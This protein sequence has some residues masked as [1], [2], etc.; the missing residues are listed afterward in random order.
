MAVTEDRESAR[1]ADWHRLAAGS[2]PVELPRSMRATAGCTRSDGM[3]RA[4]VGLTT[5][6]AE[7]L[8]LAA[9]AFDVQPATVIASA[10]LVVL[11][12]YSSRRD[13]RTTLRTRDDDGSILVAPCAVSWTA[14]HTFGELVATVAGAMHTA[15]RSALPID[16]LLGSEPATAAVLSETC[17]RLG[18]AG[19]ASEVV[20]ACD[21]VV[22]VGAGDDDDVNVEIDGEAA[23]PVITVLGAADRFD[24]DAVH[25]VA[26]HL[27]TVIETG[28]SDPMRRVDELPL[29]PADEWEQ[30]VRSWN[31]TER[32]RPDTTL[33]ELID[34]QV[35][36]T[37]DALAVDS[38]DGSLTYEQLRATAE[39]WSS[40]LRADGVG[41]GQ[42]VAVCVPRGTDMVAAVLAV[43]RSGAAYLPI[44]PQLPAERVAFM[45]RDSDAAAVLCTADTRTLVD[46]H[47]QPVHVLSGDLRAATAPPAEVGSDD[48]AY[49]LYTSGS[50]GTPKGV[51]LTHRNAVNLVS[52]IRDTFSVEERRRIMAATS[53]SWDLSITELFGSLCWGTTAVIV[54][55]VLE[56]AERPEL[57]VTWVNT[58]PSLIGLMI[59]RAPLAA[60]VRVVTLAGEVTSRELANRIHERS[61]GARLWIGYGPTETTTYST[62]D[63]VGAGGVTT[64]SIGRPI[65]NNQ[66]YLLDDRG[67][68]VPIGCVGEIVIGGTSVSSGYLNR[69]ELTAERFVPDPFSTVSGARLYRTGDYARCAVDGA[70]DFVGRRDDQVKIHGVRIELGEIES[71]LL[72]L[73][74]VHRAVVT[75]QRDEPEGRGSARIVAHV[76]PNGGGELDTDVLRSELARTL[77]RSMVPAVIV[78]LDE[79][80]LNPNGKLDRAALPVPACSIERAVVAARRPKD[81]LGQLVASIVQEAT[82]SDRQLMVDDDFFDLGG[83]SLAAVVMFAEFE[84]RCGVTLPVATLFDHSTVGELIEVVS[85]ATATARPALSSPMLLRD[86]PEAPALFLM[87]VRTGGV[88]IHRDLVRHLGGDRPVHGLQAPGLDGRR[89]AVRTLRALAVALADDIERAQPAGPYLLAGFSFGGMVAVEVADVLRDRGHAVALV[90]MLDV[91]PFGQR[92]VR[93][94][95]PRRTSHPGVAGMR[96]RVALLRDRV[97]GRW[98][99]ATGGRPW[100]NPR[101]DAGS[102]AERVLAINVRIADGWRP[103]SL[104]FPTALIDGQQPGEAFPPPPR[105]RCHAPVRTAVVEFDGAWHNRFMLD[106]QAAHVAAELDAAI[107]WAMR[108]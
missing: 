11:G 105:R 26:G 4:E 48:P 56:L 20:P 60:S 57:D 18:G 64:P 23:P 66:V 16:A 38:S 50:T 78:A 28:C 7:R 93:A 35:D 14:D 30:V 44:D 55:D 69:P 24:P 72:E 27:Q 10:V 70:H 76:V 84:S 37:P 79:L 58:S 100:L 98:W 9:A 88:L 17:L 62:F 104:E 59:D 68:P 39:I 106:P 51:V 12:R 54:R 65:D 19:R 3:H 5:A 45:L 81:A 103:R 13:A 89:P 31:R 42:I 73:P 74:D 91:D 32:D 97:R 87:P 15:A 63:V 75:V 47:A 49:V 92:P 82:A 33:H 83:D 90:A 99:N 43:L 8:R 53:L 96:R 52:W 71:R 80:P 2:D 25:R 94:D 61:A 21:L 108:R 1:I 40:Q 77:P 41:R 107:D 46:G 29:L 102:D 22:D 34:H 101:L 95:D 6:A 36:R 67:D 85:T 86:G